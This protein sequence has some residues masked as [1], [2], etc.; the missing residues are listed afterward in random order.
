MHHLWT[1]K[2]CV[3]IIAIKKKKKWIYISADL[4]LEPQAVITVFYAAYGAK[5]KEPYV[6]NSWYKLRNNVPVYI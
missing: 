6:N 3:S 1:N 5:C 2:E 4:G